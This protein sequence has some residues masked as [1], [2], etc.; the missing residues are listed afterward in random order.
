MVQVRA[1]DRGDASQRSA[2][3]GG[4]RRAR[5]RHARPRTS[6][7]RDHACAATPLLD[8]SRVDL[9][10]AWSATTHA[11]AAPARQPRRRR[12]GIRPDPRRGAIPGSAPTLDLRSG[13]RTSPRRSSRAARGPRSRSCASRASTARSRWRPRSTAPGFAAFDVHMSDIIAGR[14]RLADFK[15]FVACGGF[16]YGDVLGAGEGWAKSILFNARARDEFAAFFARADTFALGVCNGCQMMSNLHELIPGTRPLAALR[17]QP[18]R[19]VRGAPRDARGAALAV[20][21]LRGHGG[22]PHADRDRAR[23]GLRRVSRRG[24]ARRRRSRCVAAALRRQ[25][26][27]RR[28]SAIRTIRTARRRASPGSPRPT[29]ASRS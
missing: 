18:L 14:R 16:S 1:R 25:R 26:A 27:A 2:R 22:Q 8:E 15:G 5:D 21:L 12:P 10:R 7:V 11:H 3:G 6:R 20:A 23:R 9:H 4:P 19:A 17:A 28:P 29:A 13:A 24:A